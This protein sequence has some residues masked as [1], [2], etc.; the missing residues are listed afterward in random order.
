MITAR[1]GNSYALV[2]GINRYKHAAP[3]G[4]AVNDAKAVAQIL[5]DRF[6]FDPANVTLLLDKQ[7]TR[8]AILEKYLDLAVGGTNED[9]R[10]FVFFAGHGLTETSRRQE[11]GFLV[12]YDGNSETISS[13][14]RWDELT[15]NADLIRAKHILFIMDA[16]YGGL[17]IT[18]TLKPGAARFLEDMLVRP[19]RQVLTAGKADEV[20]AD[21]GGPRPGHSVFT[22][23]LLDGLDGNAVG[24]Q[25][26][27]TANGLMAYVYQMVGHDK[28]SHQTPHYGYLDGDGDFIFLPRKYGKTSNESKKGEETLISVPTVSIDEGKDMEIKSSERI[29]EYLSE[30]RF[31]IK[32]HDYVVEQTRQFLALTGEDKISAQGTWSQDLFNERIKIYEDYTRA[33]RE[34][35]MLI[36]YWGS[37]SHQDVLNLPIQ[38]IA[39]R[40]KTAA[41]LHAWLFLR[42]YPELLLLYSSGIASCASGRYENLASLLQARVQNPEYQDKTLSVVEIVGERYF[43]L[44]EQFKTMPGYERK[45]SPLSEYLYQMLQSQIDDLFFLGDEYETSFDR[46]ETL[47][48][49]EFAE[50]YSRENNREVFGPLGRFAWKFTS[51]MG[52][53]PLKTLMLEAEHKN[54]DWPP[55]RAGLFGGSLDRFFEVAKSF[56]KNLQKLGWF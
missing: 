40:L 31:K 55:I 48:S 13:L 37:A 8:K 44:V 53:G 22:G 47:F 39:N 6:D 24:T 36:A 52:G 18:R 21:L 51:R 10:V 14:I 26:V 17:A 20:V 56:E 5:S 2:I 25:G 54:K 32:L 35:G 46:F 45:Y 38:R 43:N 16:C 50:Q 49:L 4:Y 28:D 15:R 33:L 12:P 41:G 19:A 30:D 42:W 29:K 3:L 7:A 9:D 34:S 1:Y 23:H 27:L 11:V